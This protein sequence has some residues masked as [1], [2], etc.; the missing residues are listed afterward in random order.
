MKCN[1][2]NNEKHGAFLMC[3]QCRE[4]QRKIMLKF[5]RAYVRGTF[6]LDDGLVAWTKSG[7]PIV[8]WW[9]YV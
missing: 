1:R 3:V 6:P 2:C 4:K 7:R 8:K 5:K 9:M